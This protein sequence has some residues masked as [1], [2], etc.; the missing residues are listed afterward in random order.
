MSKQFYFKKFSLAWVYSFVKFKPQVGIRFFQIESGSG[1]KKKYPT[2]PKLQHYWSLTFRLFSVITENALGAFYTFVKKHPTYSTAPADDYGEK[3]DEFPPFRR[4]F[5]IG[6]IPTS[7]FRIRNRVPESNYHDHILCVMCTFSRLP[8]WKRW[9]LS[10]A[11]MSYSFSH[12][13]PVWFSS[14]KCTHWPILWGI[15][16]LW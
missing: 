1:E 3:V 2:F 5:A 4:V 15:N 9:P 16:K 14:L 13:F 6:E 10:V 7:S 12:A 8:K 11:S